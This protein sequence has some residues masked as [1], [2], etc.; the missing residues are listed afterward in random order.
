VHHHASNDEPV[1]ELTIP[2]QPL[3]LAMDSPLWQEDLNEPPRMLG[4]SHG[5]ATNRT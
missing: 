5:F 1:Y 3:N 2:D 4:S